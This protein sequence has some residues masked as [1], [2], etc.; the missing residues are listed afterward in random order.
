M[1]GKKM[2][3]IK[4][5]KQNMKENNVRQYF[6]LYVIILLLINEPQIIWKQLNKDKS[7]KI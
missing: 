1:G 7:I 4:Y 2:Y 5:K 3:K 6:I